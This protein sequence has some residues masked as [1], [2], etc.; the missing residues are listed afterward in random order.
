MQHR[1]SFSS[2]ELSVLF[3]KLER[4][5]QDKREISI[6]IDRVTDIGKQSLLRILTQRDRT[7]YL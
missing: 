2:K 4:L 7:P 1:A 6:Q 3:F 5:S